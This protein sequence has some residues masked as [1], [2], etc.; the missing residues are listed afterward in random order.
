MCRNIRQLRHPEH[1]PSQQELEDAALQ[2]VRKISGFRVP[3]TAN[4]EPFDRAVQEITAAS[5]R[6]FDG[7]HTGARAP[8]PASHA[9]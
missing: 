6:L 4:R 8:R 3:S 5:R 7:L 2:F 1:S 9:S